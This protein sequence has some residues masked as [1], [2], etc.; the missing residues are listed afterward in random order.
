MSRNALNWM[1]ARSILVNVTKRPVKSKCKQPGACFSK[2][3]RTFRAQ[4]ASCQTA[5]A[6]SEKLI[7]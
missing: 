3:P 7:F 6:C 4:N 5:T 2:V 1:D